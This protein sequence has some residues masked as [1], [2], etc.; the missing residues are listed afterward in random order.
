MLKSQRP[1]RLGL[2]IFGLMLAGPLPAQPV[3]APD[4]DLADAPELPSAAR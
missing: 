1:A 4:R 3:A 2:V